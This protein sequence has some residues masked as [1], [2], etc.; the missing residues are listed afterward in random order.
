MINVRHLFR[1]LTTPE[2]LQIPVSVTVSGSIDAAVPGRIDGTVEGDVK[3]TGKLIISETARIK[4]HVFA[5]ELILNG[6]VYGNVYVSDKAQVLS[7]A[8]VK[9]DVNA[10][11]LEVEVGA[12]IGGVTRKDKLAVQELGKPV[13][14]LLPDVPVE[15]KPIEKAVVVPEEDQPTSWF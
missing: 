6:K 10:F 14:A 4:G 9:G 15:T 5:A 8:H 13:Q 3:T 12:H 1:N 2:G 11:S 7:A